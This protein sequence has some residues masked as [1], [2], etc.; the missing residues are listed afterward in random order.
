MS[1]IYRLFSSFFLLSFLLVSVSAQQKPKFKTVMW[2]KSN[3][4]QKDLFHGPGGREMLPNL[5]KITFIKEEEEG[6]NKKYRIKDGAGRTWVAKL[7]RE[8]QSETAAVRLMWA[9][10][11]KTE[12]NYLV[13]SLTIPGKG[14][15][16]NVRLE[17][18]PE[19]IERT[20][21]WSWKSNPFIGTSEFEGLR[22]MMV[23]LTNWD[24][25]DFQNKI[26]EVNGRNGKEYH[27][28]IS[29]MG[30]TLGRLGNNNFP[31]FYRIG[32]TIGKPEDY[33]KAKLVRDVEGGEVVLAYKGKNR[34][35]FE[36][37]KVEDAAW[38]YNLLRQLSD[39]QIRD[40][41]RAAN[42][43]PQEVTTYTVA[44]KNR[45]AELSRAVN[46]GKFVQN[47]EE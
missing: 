46:D 13:P 2:E 44:V 12:I 10:G 43:S 14:T 20:D 7:T 40:A 35:I 22:M 31:L 4:S 32:R 47:D 36:N 21:E 23:F 42:Y 3:I 29:D 16:K 15:F 8:T 30:A 18:R 38:L 6:Y 37:V 1:K 11:Y 19:N 25:G 33:I 5:S 39:K 28:I 24:V 27:Y 17:A 41:F 45:I 34:H 26:L 9:L